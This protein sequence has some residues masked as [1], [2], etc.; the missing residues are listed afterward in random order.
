MYNN[1]NWKYIIGPSK[2]KT[3]N[4]GP[5]WDSSFKK[6]SIKS[7]IAKISKNKNTIL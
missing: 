2:N 4:K 3:V 7:L 5:T 6:E 1:F